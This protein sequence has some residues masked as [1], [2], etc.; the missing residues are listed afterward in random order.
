MDLSGLAKDEA[1]SLVLFGK[2]GHLTN[3]IEH[4]SFWQKYFPFPPFARGSPH[5]G[6]LTTGFSFDKI[7]RGRHLYRGLFRDLIYYDNGYSGEEK[8]LKR[9]VGFDPTRSFG[10]SHYS[11]W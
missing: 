10:E 1:T 5:F 4:S 9:E 6:Q 2:E 11:I 8:K 7:W 3:I